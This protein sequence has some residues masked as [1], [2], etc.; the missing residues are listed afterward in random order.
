VGPGPGAAE[1]PD[2]PWLTEAT[3]D[4]TTA[5]PLVTTG[6]RHALDFERC[7]QRSEAARW[8]LPRSSPPEA[9]FMNGSQDRDAALGFDHVY[10]VNLR[11]EVERRAAALIDLEAHGIAAELVSALD[12][13][14]ELGSRL[15]DQILARPVGALERFPKFGDL[16]RYRARHFID[17][18]GAVGYILTYVGILRDAQRR[19]FG[20]ILILEDD[21]LFVDDLRPRL[22]ALLQGIGD[23]WRVLQLGASQYDWTDIDDAASR[24][25]GFYPAVPLH[26][27]GS[28]A[29]ALDSR[30]FDELI[31]ALLW[32]EA[33]FDHLPLGEVYERHRGRC[34]VAYPNLV[35]PVVTQ[36]SIRG[37]RDQREHAERMRWP[38][39]RFQY[40]RPP[41][42]LAVVL[43]PEVPVPA[44][45]AP[46][47]GVQLLYLRQGRDGLRPAHPAPPGHGEPAAEQ[48][49]GPDV[50]HHASA[51]LAFELRRPATAADILAEALHQLAAPRGRTMTREWLR[52]LP[53]QRRPLVSGR[54][55]V[56]IPTRGRREPLE[57]A[58]RSVIDQDHADLE[59]LVVNENDPASELSEW[60][61][62]LVAGLAQARP[63]LTLRLLQH[64]HARNA[65]AARNTG[66]LAATGET[67]S[68]LDDDD[69]YLPG[70]ISRAVYC[71]YLGWNS[72][73]NDLARY[74]TDELVWRMLAIEYGSHYICT[75]TVTYR[76]HAL[77][78]INGFDEAFR[79]HQDLELNARFFARHPVQV[80]REPLV[81]LNPL[82]ADSTNKLFDVA[83][84]ETK[85][86]F[87]D[88][89]AGVIESFGARSALLMQ[90][91]AQELRDYA[92]PDTD[93]VALAL[94]RTC[95]LS[96]ALLRQL[97]AAPSNK[98]D[99]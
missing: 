16:E 11:S 69:A 88:K 81:Q 39:E 32:F 8:A 63:G 10:L 98:N 28:F 95:T 91:H 47:S 15:F 22:A 33:P 54:A 23:D 27:C 75:N 20:K 17:S 6:C 82:L 12:G 57:L 51:D 31:E 13:S 71:G 96:T 18:R 83:L 45:D 67:V 77:L 4:D 79:R 43:A 36:S 5:T 41:A 84:F 80:L 78:G 50:L 25:A 55:S 7:Q 26:T 9:R 65:A 74:P 3:A 73:T 58:L 42:Q 56:V 30:V 90:R 66:L 70:R 53:L 40:P 24:R 1:A 89:F 60:L 92:N 61:R 85:W 76:T 19:G 97:L 35:M 68:F 49:G 21:V 2:P 48:A 46:G 59:V 64:A 44:D 87:L 29:M 34:F 62:G 37:P 86:R 38:I 14:D 93:L 52:R 99:D 72:K 94:G